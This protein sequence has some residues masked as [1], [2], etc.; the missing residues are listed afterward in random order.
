MGFRSLWSP[1]QAEILHFELHS[2]ARN[3]MNN[4]QLHLWVSEGSA[5]NHRIK[6]RVLHLRYNSKTASR[7]FG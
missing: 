1:P 4:I 6:H 7:G 2:R 5:L 3:G